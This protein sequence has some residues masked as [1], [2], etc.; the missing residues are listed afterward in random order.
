[1]SRNHDA[2]GLNAG[3]SRAAAPPVMIDT[4]AFAELLG[5]S[6]RHVRRM[7]D[8]G[9]C[10]SPVRLGGCVRWP[11]PAVDAWIADGCPNCRKRPGVA[12]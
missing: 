10:P 9:K 3:G 6:T 4:D 1:M 8:A 11:R 2:A 5:V 12:R 7:A